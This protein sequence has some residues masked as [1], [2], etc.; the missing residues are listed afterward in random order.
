MEGFTFFV[1]GVLPYI[2]VLTFVAG[3]AYRFYVWKTTPQPGK[4]TLFPAP[5]GG[6]IRGIIKEVL[7]FPSLFKGDRTLWTISWVFHAMV[8]LVFVGHLRVFSG[9]I[10]RALIPFIGQ[11]GVDTMSST[12]G[13]AAGIVMLATGLLLLIRRMTNER[14]KQISTGADFFALLLV[15]SIVVTGDLMRFSGAHF[16]LELTRVWAFSLLTFSPQVPESS[17][18]LVHALLAQVLLIYIPFS[19]ILHF[20]GIFFTQALVQ[21]R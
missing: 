13:G 12:A 7:F 18:F 11:G 3:M 8:A 21:R 17:M 16:D 9:L 15:L 10:D 6:M 4:M 19:K 14:V 5:E 20:G 2:A 1:G